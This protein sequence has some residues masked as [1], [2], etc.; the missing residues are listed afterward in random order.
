[1]VIH[2]LLA[3]QVDF[4]VALRSFEPQV[5]G[6]RNLIDLALGSPL[7]TPPRLLYTSSIGVLNRKATR[8]NSFS[9]L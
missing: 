5:K 7:A 2:V 9:K 6:V 1:M 3:W 4:N 8:F